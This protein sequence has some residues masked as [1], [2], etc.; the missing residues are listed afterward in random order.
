M[1]LS[2]THGSGVVSSVD[3]ML[4]MSVVHGVRGVGRVC[5]MCMGLARGKYVRGLGLARGKYVRGLGL[6][7]TNPVG[8]GGV[9]DMCL[10]LG[11]GGVWPGPASGRMGWCY[12][13]VCCESGLFV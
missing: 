10:C 5:E 12:D 11:C 13:C 2:A 4:E 9:W 6:G 1:C 8:S 3:D 7:F